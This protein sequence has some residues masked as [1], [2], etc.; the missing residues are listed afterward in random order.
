MTWMPVS[1]GTAREAILAELTHDRWPDLC[2]RARGGETLTE[3][4]S[5]IGTDPTIQRYLKLIDEQADERRR[6]AVEEQIELLG[7]PVWRM[8]RPGRNGSR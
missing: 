2:A 1:I 8:T 3:I 4:A 6:Q 5:S 7:I